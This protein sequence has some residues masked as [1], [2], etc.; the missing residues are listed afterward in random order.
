MIGAGEVGTQL[1]GCTGE[2]PV[3]P[4]PAAVIVETLAV[5]PG[6]EQ[7][8]SSAQRG[9]WERQRMQGRTVM[10]DF[11]ALRSAVGDDLDCEGPSSRFNRRPAVAVLVGEPAVSGGSAAS[12]IVQA[13]GAWALEEDALLGRPRAIDG[14]VGR[15]A[16]GWV[17][18]LEWLGDAAGQALV[19][20]ALAAAAARLIARLRRAGEGSRRAPI[21]VSRGMAAALAADHIARQ[22]AG[23]NRLEIEA[24][25]EPSAIAGRPVSELSYVGAEPWLVLARSRG[26]RARFYVVVAPDGSIVGVLR[27]PLL[28]WEQ[29]A[30]A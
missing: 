21:Y 3:V 8:A 9:S 11:S 24:V 4:V 12:A 13:L 27:T 14:T 26:G 23:D 2:P 19:D 7:V 18:V 10:A 29:L 17:P 5:S 15:G 28:E 1:V 25:E 16:A 30:D 22:H 20:L 6:L